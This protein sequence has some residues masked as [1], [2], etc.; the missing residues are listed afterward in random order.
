M[1]ASE[2]EVRWGVIAVRVP[3]PG[4]AADQPAV[5]EFPGRLTE[6][7]WSY[8]MALLRAMKAG[9]VRGPGDV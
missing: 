6:S 2:D 4:F 1:G 3:I 5:I 8:F 7:E 9:V